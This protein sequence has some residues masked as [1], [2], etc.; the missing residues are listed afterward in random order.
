MYIFTNNKSF[1][2]ESAFMY[3]EWMQTAL[4][5]ASDGLNL[6]YSWERE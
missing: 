6:T 4:M 2:G 5:A 1:Y 3:S